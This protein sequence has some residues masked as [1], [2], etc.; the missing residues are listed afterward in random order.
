MPQRAQ[1]ASAVK[2][3]IHQEAK[4]AIIAWTLLGKSPQPKLQ[5]MYLEFPDMPFM[6]MVHSDT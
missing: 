1:D 4:I 2:E 3:A 6:K 5:G